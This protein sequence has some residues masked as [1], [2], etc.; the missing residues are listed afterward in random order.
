MLKWLSPE[1]VAAE[2]LPV[3]HAHINC[4]GS[5]TKCQILARVYRRS[6]LAYPSIYFERWRDEERAV[7]NQELQTVVSALV[8][9]HAAALT[10]LRKLNQGLENNG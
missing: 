4:V 2:F 6:L 10:R 1:R 7:D 3:E 5:R 9:L 8:S